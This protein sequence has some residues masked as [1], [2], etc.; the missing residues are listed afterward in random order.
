MNI[1]EIKETIKMFKH[2]DSDRCMAY[3][4]TVGEATCDGC[5]LRY[6]VCP[7]IFAHNLPLL[8]EKLK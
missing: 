2:D 6:R 1:Y 8:K 4:L 5:H 7:I 3:C